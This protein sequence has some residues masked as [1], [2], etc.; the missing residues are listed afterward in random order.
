MSVYGPL[1]LYIVAVKFLYFDFYADPDPA[2]E[3]IADPDLPTCSL[4]LDTSCEF[5]S[6]KRRYL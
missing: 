2:S 5:G 6:C 4:P 1:R 3:S